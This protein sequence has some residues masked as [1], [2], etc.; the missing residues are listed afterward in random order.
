MFSCVSAVVGPG[1]QGGVINSTGSLQP[2]MDGV[3]G[4]ASAA[5]PNLTAAQSP[6]KTGT[7]TEVV[8]AVSDVSSAVGKPGMT[9]LQTLNGSAV[10][11]NCH[12]A[13]SGG[14][15]AQSAVTLV[16]NGPVSV[17]KGSAV[18]SS[19]APT[20]IIRT[21]STSPLSAVV[22]SQSHVNSVPTVTLVRPPMQTPTSTV[23]SGGSPTTVLTSPPGSVASTTGALV[24]KLNPTK[25]VLQTSGHTAISTVVT[26]T[27]ATIRSPTVLQ[28]LRTSVPSTIAA[29]PP[30]GIRAIAPQV[31]A[32]RLTHPQPNAPNIQNIQLPPGNL[33][34]EQN[35]KSFLCWLCQASSI[36]LETLKSH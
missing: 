16:N 14:N 30:A 31:F 33:V 7:T 2:S 20:T 25:S 27:T 23:Q 18:V 32:P 1:G 21:S 22:S 9:A 10:V 4:S 28:N 11:M 35:F 13:D 6:S 3:A 24:N 5:G 19:V 15:S 26:A 34:F 12:T 8:T 29:A 36:L 17:S